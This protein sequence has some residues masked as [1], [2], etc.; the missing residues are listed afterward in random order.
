M[1]GPYNPLDKMNL[2]RSV[3]EALLDVPVAPLSKTQRLVG[4]GVYAI[5]YTGR[6]SPYAPIAAK[7]RHRQFAQPIYVGKAIPKGGRKGG[8]S[9]DA[10]SGTALR[11]RLGQ[12]ASSINEVNNLQLRDFYF[13]AIV[14][15]DIWIPLGENMLIEQFRPVWNLVVDGF[16]NKDPGRRRSTQYRSAWDVIHPGRSFAAKLA[17]GEL[18]ARRV[19][20]RLSAFY[21]RQEVPEI[22]T[23][24]EDEEESEG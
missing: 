1:P 10:A 13:R 23:Q 16:G 4:A 21:S 15:D 2:G 14:V 19:V 7:N 3:A 18:S 22:K 5:Y 20:E 24:D 8:I 9:K 11:D 17:D 6:F 12:H